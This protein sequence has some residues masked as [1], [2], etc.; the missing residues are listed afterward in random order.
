MKEKILIVVSEFP[1]GPGGIGN[2][3]YS[4]SKSFAANNYEVHLL[5]DADYASKEDV[6]KFDARLENNII[7][8][9]VFRKS[10]NTYFDRISKLRKLIKANDYKAV[11]FSGK[12]SLWMCIFAKF[13][14]KKLPSIAVLHG[15]EV[16]FS[17]FFL[18]SLTNWGISK[19]D[20]LVPVSAFTYSLLNDKLKKKPYSIIEN[21]IDIDEFEALQQL[22]MK[23]EEE[24]VFKGEPSLLTVGNVTPRKGQHR[25]IKALP[26][27]IKKFPNIHYNIVG[28]PTYQKKLE[29]LAAQLGVSEYITFYGRL[30]KRSD[31]AKAYSLCDC[32][33]ILSENQE[34]GDVEG[35]GIVILEANFFGQ[36]AIGAS[37]CGISDAIKVDYNGYVVDGDKPVEITDALD[38]ILKNRDRL[39]DGAIKWAIDHDWDNIIKKYEDI[40]E[41]LRL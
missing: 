31:L 28:L 5:A 32:F 17:N 27:L 19:A 13:I 2:H 15:S 26:E 10:I 16:R 1:P 29:K 18:R 39:S 4:L 40:F 38:K 6:L 34:D 11:I 24:L 36:P 7:M 8:N 30:P 12:F 25:V 21:G 3:A 23:D 35:F 20:Y 9:R 37:G 33:I 41:N 22:A 14:N